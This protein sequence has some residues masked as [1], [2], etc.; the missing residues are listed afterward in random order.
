MAQ[1]HWPLPKLSVSALV[2]VSDLRAF[3]IDVLLAFGV[4]AHDVT[5]C[6]DVLLASDLW[7][8]QSHGI[9]H[10]PMYYERIRH[11]VQLP[12]T[13]YERVK[14]SPTTAVIDGGSGMGMVVAH[15][16]MELA[17]AKARE[18]GMGSVAVCNSSHFGIAGYYARMAADAGM[19][20]FSFTNSQPAI[21][22]T[23]GVEPML[24]TNPIAIAVPT[25]EPFPFLFDAATSVV[26]RGK[27]EIAAR[28]QNPIPEGW[29][30]GYTG[31]PHVDSESADAS[32]DRRHAALLP[33]GGLGEL[34][35][36]HKGYGLA[37]IVEILCAAL[38]NHADFAPLRD[39]DEHGF[40]RIGH[41]FLAIDV[42]RFLPL[43]AFRLIVGR[44][45]RDLRNSPR[46]PGE[47][48]IYTAG[49]KEYENSVRAQ[50]YGIEVTPTV[51]HALI[52]L[53]DELHLAQHLFKAT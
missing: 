20:G 16:A 36:G 9:A 53:C 31:E 13:C 17:I 50:K 49:E 24:G 12:I 18:H 44:M 27:L 33:L 38:Q 1:L 46:I 21:T 29:V 8:I 32:I 51:Q 48:R 28:A 39:V 22:P 30:I 40:R 45:M 41:F 10:L 14:E 2:P 7:G 11:G 19:I 37:T 35:G 52:S 34:F 4:P 43:Q 5:I 6:A 23:H 3:I 15:P 25:D 47:P 26:A 42:E